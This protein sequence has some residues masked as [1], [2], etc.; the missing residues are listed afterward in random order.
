MEAMSKAIAALAE[1]QL[2]AN[3]GRDE[4]RSLAESQR[5]RSRSRDRDPHGG[6]GHSY[7]ANRGMDTSRYCP[8]RGDTPS[9]RGRGGYQGG[10]RR[11]PE[12]TATTAFFRPVTPTPM[13][14]DN[15]TDDGEWDGDDAE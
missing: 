6:E 8:P 3:R 12:K 11:D 15:A 2:R 4:D 13:W 10:R 5:D 7:R 14:D 1:A 9:S